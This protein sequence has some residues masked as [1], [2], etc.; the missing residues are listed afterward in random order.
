[1]LLI[2]KN[3]LS[4][5]RG[6]QHGREGAAKRHEFVLPL[7]TGDFPRRITRA[8]RCAG[9]TIHATR[10]DGAERT[11]KASRGYSAAIRRPA[12]SILKCSARETRLL[13][14]SRGFRLNRDYAISDDGIVGRGLD[15]DWA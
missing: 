13:C 6:L 15:S 14:T 12:L 3:T 1:M 9:D 4:P 10:V 2:Q 8:E 11:K 7:S 5:R